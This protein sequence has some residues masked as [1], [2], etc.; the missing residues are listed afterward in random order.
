MNL[1]YRL[2]LASK[3]P[4]RQELLRSLD[5]DFEVRVKPINESF[6]NTLPALEVAEY[7]AKQKSQAFGHLENDELVITSDTVVI[8]D[9]KILGK[10]SNFEEAFGMIKSLS[11]KTHQV[12]TG[13]CLRS[14]EKTD[15]FTQVTEVSFD[16][17][18][19]KLIEYYINMYQPF[20][21]AGSYGIQEWIGMIGINKIEGD[22][23]NVMGLPLNTLYKRLKEFA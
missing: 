22:Y 21:K 16:V 18:S 13:V 20:D 8:V 2:I 10:S 12:A 1:K 23:Y 11:G 5:L 3:S 7:L 15:C 14:Q 6:P 9:K 19:D 4:R 17:L